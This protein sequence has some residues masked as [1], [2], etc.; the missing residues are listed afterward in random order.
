MLLCTSPTLT[1]VVRREA[2]WLG[3]G[4]AWLA[5]VAGLRCDWGQ[6]LT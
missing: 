5:L 3:G 4:G 2:A 6:G 1:A